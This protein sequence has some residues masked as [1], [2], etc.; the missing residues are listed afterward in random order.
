MHILSTDEFW[1]EKEKWIAG[2]RGGRTGR[3]KREVEPD[4]LGLVP[5][6]EPKHPR[7]NCAAKT[8][9]KAEKIVHWTPGVCKK[10][11]GGKLFSVFY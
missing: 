6:S 8:Y 9:I 1:T 10:S 7:S 3:K 5:T 4:V 11:G 2:L